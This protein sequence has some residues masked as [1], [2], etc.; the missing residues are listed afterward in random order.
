VRH[1]AEL[2]GGSVAATSPGRG[3]GSTM[4]V[5]LPVQ[6]IPAAALVA[7]APLES[8]ATAKRGPFAVLEGLRVLLIEDDTDAR[9]LVAAILLDAGAIVRGV[10]SAAAA[11]DAFPTFRPQLLV[12]DVAMPDE[13]GYSL[14][15]RIRALGPAQGGAVPAIA[16]TAYTR[17]EDRSQALAA[18]FTAH[19]GKPVNP[20]ELI[21][22]LS[23]LAALARR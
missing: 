21:S 10:P 7:S 22:A 19:I 12:S 20:L 14:M 23:S 13:D 6:A 2:H 5:T 3:K 18:G 15:R 4:S 17:A 16:L 1:I 11:L 9:E 8:T